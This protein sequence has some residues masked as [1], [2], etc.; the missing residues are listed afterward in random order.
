MSDT[1]RSYGA[2]R[3]GSDAVYKHAAPDGA[4]QTASKVRSQDKASDASFLRSGLQT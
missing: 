2:T 3:Q 1:F 4:S